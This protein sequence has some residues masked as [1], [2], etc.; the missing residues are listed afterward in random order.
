[1]FWREVEGGRRVGLACLTDFCVNPDCTCEEANVRAFE[2]DDR[3]LRISSRGDSVTIR[4]RP[5]RQDEGDPLSVAH[6]VATVDLVSGAV[7]PHP[8][9]TPT[10]KQTELLS[11]LSA[12]VDAVALEELR[13]RW[14]CFKEQRKREAVGLAGSTWEDRDWTWWDGEEPVSWEEVAP[15]PAGEPDVFEVEGQRYEALDHYCLILD[16][17]CEE[18]RIHFYVLGD[19]D[20]VG[21]LVGRVWVR[22]GCG[23]IVRTDNVPGLH[24]TVERL[25]AAYTSRHDLSEL[26]RRWVEMKRLGPKVEALRTQQ[27]RPEPVRRETRIGRNDPCPCGSGRKYKKCCLG[28][29][30]AE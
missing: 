29:E 4:S 5:T 20:E 30:A 8:D 16:C 10:P 27:L 18:V 15:G 19:D 2:V 21:E 22:A 1:V 23:E 6:V 13:G 26:G 17:D 12:A 25:A 14:V 28:R 7:R 24:G 9:E 3:F 11:W